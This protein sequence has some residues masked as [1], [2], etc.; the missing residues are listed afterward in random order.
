MDGR[1]HPARP[2]AR[3]SVDVARVQDVGLSGAADPDVLAP[4]AGEGRV[5]VTHDANTMA[6]Y[7]RVAAGARMPGLVV[8]P[9]ALAL[10]RAI[11]RT[12]IRASRRAIW[13]VVVAAI[14]CT[15]PPSSRAEHPEPTLV[16]VPSA[17]AG[18]GPAP[19]APP[20]PIASAIV[21]D[22]PSRPKTSARWRACCNALEQQSR[23]APPPQSHYMMSA[24]AYCRAAT[25][26]DAQ[27]DDP[28]AS[29]RAELRGSPLPAACR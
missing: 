2:R 24:A 1:R 27:G 15:P 25:A 17:G 19:S 3:V 20:S 9:P 12:G 7:A 23:A 6:A 16:V 28:S 29:I 10:V 18:P 11:P 21:A 13:A 5:V 8:V 26:T 22:E 14:G 4:A